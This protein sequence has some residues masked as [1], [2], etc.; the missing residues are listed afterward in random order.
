MFIEG[1]IDNERFQGAGIDLPITGR[2]KN[3]KTTLG[4]RPE[5]AEIIASGSGLFDASVYVVEMTGEQ[6]LV[7]VESGKTHIVITMP[8]DFETGIGRDVSVRFAAGHGFL[9]DT[10]SGDRLRSIAVVLP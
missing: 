5:D 7:T 10:I 2:A 8:K 9:F 6:T 3:A 1:V 4:F